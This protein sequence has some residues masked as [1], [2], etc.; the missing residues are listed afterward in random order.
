MKKT[1]LKVLGAAVI[2]VLACAGC[3][4]QNSGGAGSSSQAS[5]GGASSSGKTEIRFAYWGGDNRHK[6][7][8]EAIALFEKANPDIK[9]NTEISGGAG[10]H[11]MKVDTQLAGGGAPD[12]IQMG[13]NIPDYAVNKAVLLELDK[14]KGSLLNTDVIDPTVLAEGQGAWNGKLYGICLGT[15]M[16]VLAYNKG[17]L[18]RSGAALPGNAMTWAE[19]RSW[20]AEVAPKLPAGVF[21]MVD[22][23]LNQSNY[24]SYFLSQQGTVLWDGKA[25]Q[26]TLDSIQK[27]ID[28]WE[29]YRAAKLIPDAESVASYAETGPD[30]TSMFV[31]G[32]AVLALIWSNQFSAYQQAMQD[33]LDLIQLPDLNKNAIWVQ[34][35]QYLTVYKNSQNPDAAVKFIDFFVNNP[36]AAKVLGNDRGFT[37]SEI[38][39]E[40]IKQIATPV[41][42]KVYAYYDVAVPHASP[43]TGNFPNDQEFNNTYKLILQRVAFKQVPSQQGAQQILDMTQRLLKK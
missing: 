3:T 31:A 26:A 39:R 35:S 4:K 11:F 24:F 33:D 17:L 41:E 14:Y 7:T 38:A 28:M 21:P 6:I 10:D 34:P 8:A 5:S 19:M 22:N 27:W 16:L 12:L 37:S 43:F 13:G 29:D 15:N 32:K 42:Q 30:N 23:S 20:A 25:T 18:E 2:G 36:E 1:Y 40:A 9:V